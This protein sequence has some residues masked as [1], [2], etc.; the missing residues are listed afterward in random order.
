[1]SITLFVEFIGVWFLIKK[2]LCGGVNERF[3]IVMLK[4]QFSV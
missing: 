3:S 1:M 4:I 2:K